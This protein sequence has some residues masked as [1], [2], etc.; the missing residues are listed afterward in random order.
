MFCLFFFFKQKTAYEMRISD[1]SSDV[2]SSDLGPASD[3]IW[4]D[5]TRD[6]VLIIFFSLPIISC[7]IHAGVAPKDGGRSAFAVPNCDGSAPI[8][9]TSS[10]PPTRPACALQSL[11]HGFP[12]H[13]T[14]CPQGRQGPLPSARRLSDLPA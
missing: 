11:L 6:S 2:C 1:W 9:T 3:R 7:L 14:D 10:P 12:F 4:G 8:S 13:V 5:F